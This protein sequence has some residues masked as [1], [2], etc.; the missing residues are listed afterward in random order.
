M[1]TERNLR[2]FPVETY[3]LAVAIQVSIAE[4]AARTV[5][6]ALMLIFNAKGQVLPQWVA[7]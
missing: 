7:Q 2:G 1:T 4:A 3:T 6:L 5:P